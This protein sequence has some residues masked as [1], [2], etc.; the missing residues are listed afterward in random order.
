MEAVIERPGDRGVTETV[1]AAEEIVPAP[2]KR[3][4][5]GRDELAEWSRL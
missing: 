1:V 5:P 4:T 2:D 3:V